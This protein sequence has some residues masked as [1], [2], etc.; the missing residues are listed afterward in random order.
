MSDKER[1][2]KIFTKAKWSLS[3]I[4]F[5]EE[6]ANPTLIR[7]IFLTP[8]FAKAFFGEELITMRRMALD[9]GQGTLEWSKL[10]IAGVPFIHSKDY[11]L[12]ENAHR[13]FYCDQIVNL[14]GITI[15]YM[16]QYH[17]QQMVLEENLLKYLERFI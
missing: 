6:I 14:R 17:L 4:W 2:K 10:L 5:T 12:S 15:M 1:L 13:A 3:A 9:M 7:G 16:W 11:K 8:E